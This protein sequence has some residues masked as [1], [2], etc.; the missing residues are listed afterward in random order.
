VET[1]KKGILPRGW[2]FSPAWGPIKT[3]PKKIKFFFVG[4]PA[5]EE[6]GELRWEGCRSSGERVKKTGK[7]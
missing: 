3:S 6:V 2:R 4:V 5:I 1:Q 7:V